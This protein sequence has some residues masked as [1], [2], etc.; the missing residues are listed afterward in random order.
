MSAALKDWRTLLL[1]ALPVAMLAGLFSLDPI[2]Q[3][4]S[5]HLFADQRSWLGIPNFGNVVSNLAFLVVGWLGV[6]TTSGLVAEPMRLAWMVFFS[7]MVI[8]TFGSGWY[9]LSPSDQ[10]LFWDRLPMTLGF[11]VLFVAL[12]GEYFS[13]ALGRKLL[14]PM[15]MLGLV[16]V[17][18]WRYS[19]D[20]RLYAWVQF[21][22]MLFILMLL[23][24]FPSPRRTSKYLW[25]SLAAYLLAKLAELFDGNLLAASGNTISGHSIK[26]LLAAAG[27]YALIGYVREERSPR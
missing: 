19:D 3:D 23:L 17:A 25:L 8:L 9:H 27:G 18:W 26:H 22:P 24:L 14:I 12:I 15:V 20:L 21:M 13:A 4:Q 10:S 5:Y 6:R 2:A 16:S 11:M 7:G 1:A